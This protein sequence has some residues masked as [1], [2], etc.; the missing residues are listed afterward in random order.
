MKGLRIYHIFTAVLSLA[1]MA[2]CSCE[3]ENALAVINQEA[4]IESF[5]NNKYAG[6]EVIHNGSSSRI[7]LVAGDTLTRVAY[8]DSVHLE[9]DGYVFSSGPGTQFLSDERTLC[10]DSKNLVE[11]LEKGL[12]GA[13][14]GEESYIVFSAKYGYYKASVGVV[15]PMSALIYRT[16]V[17]EIKKN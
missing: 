4:Q 11:G 5:I 7:V 2:L 17:R 13:A 12:V 16:L 8:G 10:V 6:N 9:I 1:A 14:L 15:P 3:S